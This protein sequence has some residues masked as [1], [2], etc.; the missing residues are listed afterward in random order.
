MS[1]VHRVG[2][3]ENSE[4]NSDVSETSA[5]RQGSHIIRKLVALAFVVGAV[6]T[7]AIAVR[8]QSSHTPLTPQ[9]VVT[10]Q[11]TTPA[12][13][14]EGTVSLAF[15]NVPIPVV[16]DAVI[17]R[18][19]KR[20]YVVDPS[21]SDRTVTLRSTRP[22]REEDAIALL[23]QALSLA[24]A[25]LVEKSD[26]S[27]DVLVADRATG[28]RTAPVIA[29]G[30]RRAGAFL[31]VPLRYVPAREMA[32]VLESVADKQSIV[33][34]DEAREALILSGDAQ[35]LTTLTE[36][37]SLF[38]VDWLQAT[39]FD[40]ASVRNAPAET[41]AADVR[42]ALGGENGLVGSQVELVP[43]NRLRAILIIS[44]RPER[45]EPVRQ[46]IARL[47]APPPGDGRAVRFYGVKNLPAPE[48]ADTLS[49]LLGG[50]GGQ[51]GSS[52]G[53]SDATAPTQSTTTQSASASAAGV[54][55]VALTSGVRIQ[56]SPR[57]N[58]L[59]IYATEEEYAQITR[60]IDQIDVAPEQILIESTVAE[61]VL[62][63]QLKYGVQW[64][65]NTRDGGS[66]TF[67]STSS[68]SI[69]QSFPGFSYSFQG[70]FVRAALNALSAVSDVEVISSPQLVALNGQ[71]A[72]LQ[73]GD[74][75]PIITQSASGLQNDARIV[76]SVSYRDTGVVLSV[77][78]RAGSDGLVIVDVSQEVSDVSGTTSSTIDSP[79]IQQRR[80]ETRVAIQD[81]ETVALGGLI[82]SSR[83]RGNTGVPVLNRIPGIGAA[84]STRDRTIR[85]TELI[86]FLT[87][88]VIRSPESARAVTREMHERLRRL[89]NS[90][91]SEAWKSP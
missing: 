6:A 23:D 54:S 21:L 16:I 72:R 76:N 89:E 5:V 2:P 59:L 74:Q 44:K 42:R 64:F 90:G 62:N 33:R 25:R 82:R 39:H 46:W 69:A 38:D 15:D 27:V 49:G 91:V 29:G 50:T 47:D 8:A 60:V 34:V 68:G 41:I 86:V 70:Q 66:A 52:S 58:G 75:V 61:V 67:S 10:G 63:D 40:L 56:P 11:P 31:I 57:V 43:L 19:L 77:T 35:S 18:T 28:L 30:V 24:G 1:M 3:I 22:V 71:T 17:G 55:S 53:R 83:S 12:R 13:A 4:I 48:V 20:N 9:P 87:P 14:R 65:F 32:K 79:T 7:G 85:R 37:I 36:T 81:G 84:F 88:R 45:L 78:P 73:I 26:G 80:F 51:S